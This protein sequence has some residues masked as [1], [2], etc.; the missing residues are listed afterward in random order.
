ME[1]RVRSLRRSGKHKICK[2]KLS[3]VGDDVVVD[4]GGETD[5]EMLCRINYN[6]SLRV[7]KGLVGR[8]LVCQNC[9]KC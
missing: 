9:V 3:T 4:S 1:K 5:W 6:L 7:W 2:N 8:G